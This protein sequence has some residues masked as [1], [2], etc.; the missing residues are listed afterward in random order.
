MDDINKYREL[1]FEESDEYIQTLNSS[2]LELE[3]NPNEKSIIDE[4][5]RA[6]HTLK[7]MAATMGYGTMTELTHHMENVFSLFKSNEVSV[8]SENISLLFKCLDILN[9][10]IEDLR[11]EK[12]IDYDIGH[13]INSLDSIGKGT[14]KKYSNKKENKKYIDM[15]I[16]ETDMLVI[17]DAKDKGYNGFNIVVTLSDDCQLKGARSYVIINR[18]E[19]NGDIIY[20]YPSPDVL[21]TGNFD[22]E[23]KLL[24]ISKLDKETIYEA[25]DEIPEIDEIVIEDI[26]RDF[27]KAKAEYVESNKDKAIDTIKN[28]SKGDLN[29]HTNMNQS[30]RVDL[31]RLDQFMNLVSEL[32]IYRNRL[33]DI[34]NRLKIAEINVPLEQVTRITS[35]LQDLVLKIRMQP[36]SVVFN[37]FPRMIRDISK[38]LGKDLELIIE[39]EETELDRTVIS[40]LGEPLV[41]LLRNSAD[42]GIESKEA[43]ALLGKPKTGLIKL[44]AY[45]E[46]NKVIITVSDDGKGIKQE[47]LDKI[48]DQGFS[49]AKEV[50]NISG[51]GVGMDVVKQKIVSLG[52]TIDVS[53]EENKGTVF[54]INLPLTLSIMQSLM[55]KVGKEVFALPLGI[56]EKVVEIENKEINKTQNGEIYIYRGQAIPVIRLDKKLSLIFQ[57]DG[58]HL[59]IITLGSQYYGLVVDELIGQQEIVIKKLGGLL[60]NTKEFLGATILGNGNIVLIL[61]ASNLCSE[62]KSDKGETK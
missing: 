42:H 5:F 51:R 3:N 37:R 21:E 23:I 11:E 27:S 41:H 16:D 49:T 31:S 59:I 55:I 43:R 54:T 26:D 52:G 1:F 44:T 45:Q 40:E 33:D 57:S 15:G 47:H 50:T 10:I 14:E 39:G 36:I 32:V 35:D 7:G 38:E 56:I 53:S 62:G 60:N 20:S 18:L 28:K 8:N 22:N 48:F 61:D 25:I 6:A 17:T 19:Q 34:S 46:G 13:I 9:E 58:K 29:L 24:Y 4:I 2:L 12:Y 30:I